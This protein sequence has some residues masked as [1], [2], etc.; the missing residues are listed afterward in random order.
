MADGN[1]L[2]EEIRKIDDELEILLNNLKKLDITHPTY[3]DR[4]GTIN[5]KFENLL[6]KTET[7]NEKRHI[8]IFPRI[9][10][11]K[12]QISS[13]KEGTTR[14][15]LQQ[16]I[17]NKDGI[18]I[19]AREFK[20]IYQK[21]Y[22]RYKYHIE[23][24]IKKIEEL[25]NKLN[26]YENY[27]ELKDEFNLIFGNPVGK[28]YIAE[29]KKINEIKDMINA[30]YKNKLIEIDEKTAL[31]NLIIQNLI[32]KCRTFVYNIKKINQL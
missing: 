25:L 19:K 9:E 12:N 6:G 8:Y 16:R 30:D 23:N 11:L 3:S 26:K 1:Y 27:S 20:F 32:P 7:I 29:F 4:R 10:L 5:I 31:I 15:E 28:S 22:E 14:F 2:N 17:T 21:K 18:L 13:L 24:L